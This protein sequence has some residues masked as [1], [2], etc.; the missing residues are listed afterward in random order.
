MWSVNRYG[1]TAV[2]TWAKIDERWRPAIVILRTNQPQ[3]QPCVI[4][5]DSAWQWS[6]IGDP[7]PRARAMLP[8][9]GIDPWNDDNVFKLISMVQDRMDD[10]VKMP[11]RP[12]E[13]EEHVDPVAE[14][15][16]DN[17]I[18]GKTEVAL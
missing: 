2:G 5:L 8:R 12:P 10:L 18:T 6:P 3:Y 11:P 1:L 16:I 13:A 7:Y 14:V 4:P 17:P 9:L 15:T